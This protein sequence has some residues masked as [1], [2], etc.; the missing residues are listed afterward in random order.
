MSMTRKD[1]VAIAG[2]LRKARPPVFAGTN[3]VA[4]PIARNAW[5]NACTEVSL[6]LAAN[7]RFEPS[8]FFDDCGV[9]S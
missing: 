7:P 3:V 8:R 5:Y 9:P 6:V 2:A 4:N 1:Y